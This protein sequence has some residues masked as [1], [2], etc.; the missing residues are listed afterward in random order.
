MLI[1]IKGLDECDF[2]DYRD[3][4]MFVAF[5]RCSFKC[6][7]LNG[8]KVCQNGLLANEPDIEFDTE[9][10]VARYIANPLTH[11][12][13]CGGLE[14]F[15]TPDEL[16]CLVRDFRMVTDDPIIIYTGYTKEELE[17]EFSALLDKF[18]KWRHVIIK[19]GRFIM[20]DTPRFDQVLQVKLAS[21]NQYAE[22]L[23]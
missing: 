23:K 1:K 22:E 16:L 8:C 17:K 9:K 2:V 7:K 21:S 10:M 18:R 4:S 13:V 12:I 20:N 6:D 11:A 14:P 3:P 19:Y 5:P 15:D